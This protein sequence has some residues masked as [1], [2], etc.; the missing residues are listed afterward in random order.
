MFALYHPT[1]WNRNVSLPKTPFLFTKSP[2]K[3][4]NEEDFYRVQF[5]FMSAILRTHRTESLAVTQL[6]ILAIG[7]S[8]VLSGT[9]FPSR[10]LGMS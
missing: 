5:S 8:P 6:Y 4:L 3:V 10:L 1:H 9:P 2:S 7:F